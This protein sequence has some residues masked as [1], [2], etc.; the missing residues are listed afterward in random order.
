M[1]GLLNTKGPWSWPELARF[2]LLP[3]SITGCGQP[4]EALT[5]S[6]AGLCSS[7][8]TLEGALRWGRGGSEHPQ[9][10]AA[11]G[12]PSCPAAPDIPPTPHAQPAMAE[13]LTVPR[14]LLPVAPSPGEAPVP[15]CQPGAHHLF[16]P[17]PPS[18]LPVGLTSQ[19]LASTPEPK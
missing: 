11:L 16:F 3:A 4:R 13:L 1:Q 9:A 12:P 6:Q 5:L 14:L 19:N 10:S 2:I 17:S 18:P 8:P 7:R 15:R